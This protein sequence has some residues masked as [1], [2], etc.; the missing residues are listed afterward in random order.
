MSTLRKE[1]YTIINKV[2]SKNLFSD[3]LLTQMSK[4]LRAAG[5]NADLLYMLVKGVIKMRANLD[6]VIG[7]YTDPGKW[8]NTALKIKIVL[9]LGFY[10]MLYVDSV[11][12]HAAVDETVELAK[13]MFNSKVG[14]FCNAVMRAYLRKPQIVYPEDTAKR[15]AAEYSFPEDIVQTWIEY[16]GKENT[17]MLCM[18]YNDVPALHIRIN[19]MATSKQRL[20]DYFQRRSIHFKPSA[21]SEN[22]LT[23]TQ[24]HDV[25]EDVAFLEGYYSVQDTSAML[26][27]ELLDPQMNESILDLFAA[28]GG[29]ATYMSEIMA[30]TG[31][32][33]AVDKFPNKIKRL[34]Q[35]MERLQAKNIQAHAMDAFQYGP[36]A[37]AFDKVLLDVP[38]S[39][40]GVFQKKSELRWQANQNMKELLKLQEN[41][42]KMGASFVKPGGYLIYSTCTLNRAE[43]QEQVEKFLKKNPS[44]KLVPA[45]THIPQEYVDNGYLQTIPFL[46]AM[47]GAFA[48]KMQRV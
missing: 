29:K 10:Q 38:C 43:N 9:Y 11:P 15:I 18:Y 30:N 14:D 1:A 8:S 20:M 3:K 46:H 37:P 47:D 25:L 21:A 31:E 44:F 19:T 6:Y 26:V 2:L 4:R 36:V 22:V 13:K 12:D 17:E 33:I 16:W 5:E 40:W 45:A 34:K 41:A 7:Q 39:G 28:P 23:S 27:V 42:L 32:I 35:A 24:I 48:A